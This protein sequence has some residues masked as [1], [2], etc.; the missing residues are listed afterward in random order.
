MSRNNKNFKLMPI[1]QHLSCQNKVGSRI[2]FYYKVGTKVEHIFRVIDVIAS[3]LIEWH[4]R[5]FLIINEI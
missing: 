5:D 3:K 1:K 4:T 2:G